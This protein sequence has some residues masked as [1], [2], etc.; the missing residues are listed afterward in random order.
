[1]PAIIKI[2]VSDTPWKISVVPT[3]QIKFLGFLLDSSEMRVKLTSE[4]VQKIKVLCQSLIECLN[5][6]VQKLAEIIGLIVSSFPGVE[7]GPLNYRD[8]ERD[9]TTALKVNKGD[10]SSKFT[11]SQPA[12][13]NLKWWHENIENSFK[14]ISHGN[15]DLVITTDASNAGWGAHID[16]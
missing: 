6:S 12:I 7:Y 2:G 11:L 5:T 3:K 15:P 4:K 10:F 13:M 8:L 1:M 16:K 9:K 14:E